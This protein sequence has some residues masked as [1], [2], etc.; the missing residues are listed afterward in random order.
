MT[1]GTRI[2][3]LDALASGYQALPADRSPDEGMDAVGWLYRMRADHG[4][5]LDNL[6]RISDMAA[7]SGGGSYVQATQARRPVIGTAGGPNGRPYVDFI[8]ANP[9]KL[10]ANGVVLPAASAFSMLLV[11]RFQSFTGNRTI[12]G[13]SG[14][15]D[16]RY[17]FATAAGE[18]RFKMG[19]GS[20]IAPDMDDEA[21][22]FISILACYGG[23]PG[24]G[25]PTGALYIGADAP[26]RTFNT[27]ANS[28]TAATYIGLNAS[29]STSA[30]SAM[31]MKICEYALID[32]DISGDDAPSKLK[33][34]EISDYIVDRYQ[35]AAGFA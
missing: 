29:T 15:A 26:L 1:V 28:P 17:L 22:N 8:A 18:L 35:I 23:T 24:S 5:S 11:G 2:R 12:W 25:S 33:R 30:A 6:S 9:D 16:S 32:S 21:G 31:D 3:T 34:Q 7:L 19:N 14:T 27:T 4:V 20:L 13:Q 10:E